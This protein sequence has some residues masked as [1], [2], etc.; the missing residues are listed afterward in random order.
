MFCFIC[1]VNFLFQSQLYESRRNA[2]EMDCEEFEVGCYVCFL[3]RDVQY[4]RFFFPSRERI[5]AL[6][7]IH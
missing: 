4:V 1:R 6:W 2:Y 3:F 5:I 7:H